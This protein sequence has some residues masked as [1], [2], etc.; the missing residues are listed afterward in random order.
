MFSKIIVTCC[1][2]SINVIDKYL[3]NVSCITV[4]EYGSKD[5]YGGNPCA[6]GAN[7][8]SLYKYLP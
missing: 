3:G 2:Y 5:Y 8:V 7:V 6:A 4:Y 1:D